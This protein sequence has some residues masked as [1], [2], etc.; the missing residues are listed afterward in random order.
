MPTNKEDSRF[1]KDTLL[2]VSTHTYNLNMEGGLWSSTA[3]E[4]TTF[5]SIVTTSF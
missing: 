5:T 1:Q 2:F 3:L 4:A